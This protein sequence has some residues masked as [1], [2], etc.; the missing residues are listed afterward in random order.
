VVAVWACNAQ[1]TRLALDDSWAHLTV[2]LVGA[3]VPAL[4]LL[5]RMCKGTRGPVMDKPL[6]IMAEQKQQ[7][8]ERQCVD[9]FTRRCVQQARQVVAGFRQWR[10]A[11][12]EDP[13]Q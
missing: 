3:W 11:A 12:I 4:G 9:R 2:I 10:Q 5:S 8:Q 1:V 6:H 13:M 7:V